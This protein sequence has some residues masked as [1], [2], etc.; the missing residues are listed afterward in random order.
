MASKTAP[1]NESES[2][3][4]QKRTIWDVKTRALAGRSAAGAFWLI[5]VAAASANGQDRAGTRAVD[6]LLRLVPP[7]S[8]IVLTVDGL[9]DRLHAITSSKLFAGLRQLPAVKAW[10]ESEKGQQLVHSRNQI[11]TV[12][13]VKVSEICDELLGDTVVLA[14]RISPDA[15][16]DSSQARGLLLFR[17]RDKALL[18]RLVQAINAKQKEGGELARLSDRKHGGTTYQMREFPPAAERPPE[19]YVT[20]PDGTFAFSNSETLLQSVI[21]RKREAGPPSPAGAIRHP[22]LIRIRHRSWALWCHTISGCEP[23]TSSRCAGSH[24]RRA[25]PDRTADRGF[26]PTGQRVRTQNPGDARALSG[27]RRLR[28]SRPDL[29]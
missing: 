6:P 2:T 23:P 11:E 20:Y 28:R 12:L 9:R 17:A 29:E 7:D 26:S 16:A 14:L 3:Q 10:I 27:G 1:T 24:L 22:R 19:W 4:R 8:A 21:D 15:P 25:P 5:L 13:G 18:E